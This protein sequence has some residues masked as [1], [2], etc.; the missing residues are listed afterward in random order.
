M[1]R[2]RSNGV[3]SRLGS[4]AGLVLVL[5]FVVVA[6]VG[7]AAATSTAGIT[8]FSIPAGSKS[9]AIT[10][11][12]NGTIWFLENSLNA[13][14]ELNPNT[15]AVKSFNIPTANSSPQAIVAGPDK[16]LWFTEFAGQQIG[17]IPMTATSAKQIHEYLVPQPN[18]SWYTGNGANPDWI[19]LGA[20]QNLWFTDNGGGAIG[21]ITPAGKVTAYNT[22]EQPSYGG[23]I[24][25]GPN[26]TLWFTEGG[27]PSNAG[28]IT[29]SGT[30]TVTEFNEPNAPQFI[31][32]GSDDGLWFIESGNKIARMTT[33]GNVTGE[34]PVPT[35]G[36][37]L[38]QIVGGPAGTLW[39]TEAGASQIACITTAGAISEY[40]TPTP[41][42]TPVGIASGPH[43]TI[44][45]TEF[46]AG[47]V[48][49][50]TAPANGTCPPGGVQPP[51]NWYAI[52]PRISCAYAGCTVISVLVTFDTAGQVI[53]E[54]DLPHAGA[55]A[56]R[57]PQALV[58]PLH[59]SVAAGQAT[60]K[61]RLTKA[62][63]RQLRANHKLKVKVRFIFTPTGGSAATKVRSITFKQTKKR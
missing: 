14:G 63:A 44:W 22:L 53:A 21:R 26:D 24:A 7:R 23:S 52:E 19:A 11:A 2:L 57:K 6:G 32:A 36:A 17:R 10:A 8:E 40:P 31:T 12:P 54:Q 49:F 25:A 4:V 45:F 13:V 42:A 27:T 37:G 35:A 3:L 41:H 43:H 30:P 61:L 29:T 9:Y 62:G 46:S 16:A 48:G 51:S 47:K 58:K 15:G 20:D 56:K 59:R 60:L 5:A 28:R 34:Y 50:L 55:A 38:K 1:R 39:F 33:S 18:P